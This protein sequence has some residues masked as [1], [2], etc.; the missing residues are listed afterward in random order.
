MMINGF[1]KITY[2]DGSETSEQF[3]GNLDFQVS[4]FEVTIKR[5]SNHG[6]FVVFMANGSPEVFCVPNP[7]VPWDKALPLLISMNQ[8]GAECDFA[9]QT[10][11]ISNVSTW[12]NLFQIYMNPNT[13]QGTMLFLYDVTGR[14]MQRVLHSK[15][16]DWNQVENIHVSIF[17]PPATP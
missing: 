12:V 13:T 9:G 3:T 11:L 8:T 10:H 16:I 15:V 2:Q 17:L 5:D 6:T 1:V 14:P 7:T 4:H